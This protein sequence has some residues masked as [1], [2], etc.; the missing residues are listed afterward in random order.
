MAYELSEREPG[1]PVSELEKAAVRAIRRWH[2][3]WDTAQKIDEKYRDN[4]R[5]LRRAGARNA[6]DHAML[7]AAEAL[8]RLPGGQLA[9]DG[10]LYIG[11]RD[12]NGGSVHVRS[13]TEPVATKQSDP[14][15]GGD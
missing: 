6:M 3:L 8:S 1:E 11:S 4:P 12:A 15:R 5:H 13:L 7:D 10:M 2:R 9:Y 14:A